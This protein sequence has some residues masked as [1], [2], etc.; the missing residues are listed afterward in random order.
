MEL[1]VGLML[2]LLGTL[3]LTGILEWI[4]NNAIRRC[5]ANLVRE[6]LGTTGSLNVRD[7]IAGIFPR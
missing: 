3:N 7:V 4:T 6:V 1:S 5:G 2:I